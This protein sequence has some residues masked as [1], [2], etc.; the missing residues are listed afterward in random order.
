M[1][2]S[3][4]TPEHK[5]KVRRVFWLIVSVM[6]AL[7]AVVPEA[8]VPL[9]IFLMLFGTGLLLLTGIAATAIA[10][11]GTPPDMKVTKGDLWLLFTLSSIVILAGVGSIASGT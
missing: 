5:Q 6:G 8:R 1:R 7:Y 10:K 11:F 9:G 4:S 2:Q 3:E